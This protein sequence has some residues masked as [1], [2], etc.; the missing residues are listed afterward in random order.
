MNG[1]ICPKTMSLKHVLTL[2]ACVCDILAL[3]IAGNSLSRY[4]I[5][6]V[7]VYVCM[8]C[9]ETSVGGGLLQVSCKC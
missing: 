1:I 2:T 9:H 6:T 8:K 4:F 3:F 5:D 7:F